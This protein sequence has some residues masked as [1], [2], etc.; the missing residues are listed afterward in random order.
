MKT[1]VQINIKKTF[2]A[3][4]SSNQIKISK[5]KIVYTVLGKKP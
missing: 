3:E 2:T 4:T 5:P 1:S